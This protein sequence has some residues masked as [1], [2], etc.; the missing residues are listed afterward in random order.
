M[1]LNGDV[2]SSCAFMQV[3]Q[4]YTFKIYIIPDS[5]LKHGTNHN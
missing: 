2:D 5:A 3:K 4:I 1:L